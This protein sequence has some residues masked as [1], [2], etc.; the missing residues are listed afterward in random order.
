MIA[1][2]VTVILTITVGCTGKHCLLSVCL[3]VCA[4]VF[5]H[6]YVCALV[7]TLSSTPGDGLVA[8]PCGKPAL[9]PLRCHIITYVK[10]NSTSLHRHAPCALPL[11]AACCLLLAACCLL[12]AACCLLLAAC[13]L[14]LAA[15]SAANACCCSCTAH[16]I[17]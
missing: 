8:T 11:L 13:C 4:S 7:K 16:H 2:T 6:A 15:T 10:L 14:L 17:Q 5:V 9:K 1:V 12:L 3:C